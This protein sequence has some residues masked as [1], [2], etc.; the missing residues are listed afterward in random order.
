MDLPKRREKLLMTGLMLILN[1]VVLIA[2]Y[3]A[4]VRRLNTMDD[5]TKMLMAREKSIRDMI[6]RLEE[7]IHVLESRCDD[8]K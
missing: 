2:F 6:A 4:T 5:R 3:I 1:L 7:R 8:G